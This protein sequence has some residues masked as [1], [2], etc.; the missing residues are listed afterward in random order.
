MKMKQQILTQVDHA[1]IKSG[2]V[3]T[4]FLLLLAFLLDR[5]EITVFV[6]VV[7]ILGAIFP[8]LSLFGLIYQTLLKPSG[9]VKS[10]LIPDQITPHRFAQGF[11]GIVTAVSALLIW[12]G[13]GLI[14][15]SFSWLVI[16]LANLNVFAGFCAGCFTYF[17]L[18]RLKLPGFKHNP[19]QI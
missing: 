8:R 14:G 6:A 10:D 12:A 1:A 19:K 7:N 5:W 18:S 11:S 13:F 2:Q 9:L 4:M 3:M 15:W 16:M 17:Q